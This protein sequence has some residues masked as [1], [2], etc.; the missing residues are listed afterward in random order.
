MKT[1]MS[2]LGAALVAATMMLAPAA[3]AAG[4]RVGN[5][6]VANNRWDNH[7]W[8]WFI[9]H[10]CGAP[11]PDCG[12]YLVDPVVNPATDNLNVIAIPRPPKSQRFEG[13][14]FFAGGR[15]TLTVDVIDGVRCIGYNLPSHDVYDWDAASL[16]G[17][18]TSTYDAGCY[19]AP[20]GVSTYDF[21]LQRF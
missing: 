5:Y 10:S 3:N 15:Y 21:S 8:V 11:D 7:T 4:M 12:T 1:A 18:I 20:G 2:V 19:G 14:A 13:T 9:A 16:A 6:E 17:T